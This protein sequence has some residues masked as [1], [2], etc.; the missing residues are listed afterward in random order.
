MRQ[1]V[2]IFAHRGASGH[3]L[4]NTF[5]AFNKAVEMNADGIEMDLQCSKDGELFVFHDINLFRLVG[6]NRDFN[7]CLSKEIDEFKI[8]RHFLRYFINSRI[9]S[10]E[11]FIKWLIEN[12]VL[13]NI[14]LKESVLK[15]KDNL[16]AWLKDLEL[17]NGSHFS[18][19]NLELVQIVKQ[20]R[21]DFEVA[22]IVTKQ[23]N[24]DQ[25]QTMDEIDAIHASKKYYKRQFLNAAQKANKPMRFYGIKGNEQFLKYP[26]PIVT[27][28]ITDYPKK[29][30]NYIKK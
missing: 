18:S 9:P 21:P 29:V 15:H 6:I 25:L 2:K 16:V 27:G 28:W 8:G 13:V 17:P 26:H 23:F 19:F 14:E 30:A 20:V 5:Q 7:E 22:I 3:A 4:E 10:A 11:A 1:H 12:P 24:W